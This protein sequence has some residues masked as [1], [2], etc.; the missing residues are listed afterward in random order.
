MGLGEDASLLSV[1][2]R[3]DELWQRK[4]MQG[5]R[6]QSYRL[7]LTYTVGQLNSRQSKRRRE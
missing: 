1:G 7:H 2:E 3:S 4:L 6:Q 5:G